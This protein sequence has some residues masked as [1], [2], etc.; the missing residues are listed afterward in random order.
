MTFKPWIGCLLALAFAAASSFSCEASAS[1][2]RTAQTSSPS[3]GTR[4]A[5]EHAPLKLAQAQSA[6]PAPAATTPA[7][8][9]AASVGTVVSVQ[10]DASAT[11]NGTSLALK[12]NDEIFKGDTLKT[13]ANSALGVIFD[14]ETTF[15]LRANASIVVDNFVCQDGGN[16]NAAAFNVVA[17]TVAFV[18]NAVAKTGDMTISTPVST[19]GIRGTTGLVEVGPSGTGGAASDNIKLY[20]DADGHV[21]RIEIHGR[22]G[23]ALGVLTRGASGFAVRGGAG[24]RPSAVALRISPQQVA[25]D[26]ASCDKPTRHRAQVAASSCSGGCGS[27]ARRTRSNCGPSNCDRNSRRACRGRAS[28]TGMSSN[29]RRELKRRRHRARNQSSDGFSNNN[30]H[31]RAT[32]AGA[33]GAA[34]ASAGFAAATA[35]LAAARPAS[36]A[37]VRGPAWSQ[38]GART[39]TK[40]TQ[41]AMIQT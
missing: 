29:K 34:A 18:A 8:A 3:T 2:A 22:D 15:N 27:P 24:V 10:G 39:C 16:K 1:P 5:P 33:A 31:A 36:R 13:S 19:L 4:E 23:S 37:A 41:A 35:D 12:A 30:G 6:A 32:A 26:Q 28:R 7:P 25:R 21:G 20:P 40:E 38:A 14:D 9:P 17:G 11:R